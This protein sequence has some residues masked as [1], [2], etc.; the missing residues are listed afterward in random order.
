LH[1]ARHHGVRGVGV[2]LSAEQ[3]ALAWSVSAFLDTRI[4]LLSD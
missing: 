2:T 4:K 3:A 1:A